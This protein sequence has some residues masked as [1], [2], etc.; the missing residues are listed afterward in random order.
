[1]NALKKF[2]LPTALLASALV[3]GACAGSPA[4]TSTPSP[5]VSAQESN[6]AITAEVNAS[7]LMF[8]EMMIPHHEQAGEMALL[9]PT[10]G[11]NPEVLALAAK[12][13]SAQGPE[14]EQMR[15]MLDRWGV[16]EMMSHTGHQMDG[17]VSASGLKDLD[18]ASGAEFDRL[19]LTY[20][21][22]HHE[23]AIAMAQDPLVNGDDAEL[24]ALLK[25][26]VSAQN[27]EI[28]QM[29]MMLQQLQ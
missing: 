5:V 26:I 1:M 17:M 2:V 19:F 27:A 29:N 16:S 28:E 9:A 13:A 7:D 11:A 15:A 3:L 25:A 24:N 22:G 6:P 12:I 8:V 14:I 10:H 20:M 18:E 21:I 4:S 23:G